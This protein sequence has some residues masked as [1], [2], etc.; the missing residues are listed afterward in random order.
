[1][2]V[3]RRNE[4]VRRAKK[5]A[6]QLCRDYSKTRE[7]VTETEIGLIAQHVLFEGQASVRG[8]R[9]LEELARQTAETIATN[10]FKKSA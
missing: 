9:E 8:Q 5:L 10:F 1:M 6:L 4:T 3:S 7:R 2:S